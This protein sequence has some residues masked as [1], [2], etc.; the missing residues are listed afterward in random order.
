MGRE[1]PEMHKVFVSA[2]RSA[3]RSSMTGFFHSWFF[4]TRRKATLPNMGFINTII[5][6]VALATLPAVRCDAAQ[7]SIGPLSLLQQ[8]P[9]QSRTDY[10]CTPRPEFEKTASCNP[11]RQA[12]TATSITSALLLDTSS[13]SILYAFEKSS[14]TD[15]LDR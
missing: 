10:T 12:A 6:T 3:S 14:R 2:S 4:G 13:S 5:I 11:N 9:S 8:L 7:Y 15:T 1:D